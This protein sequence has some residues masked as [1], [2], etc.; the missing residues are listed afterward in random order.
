MD[1]TLT[2]H[3]GRFARRAYFRGWQEYAGL[4][5]NARHPRDLARHPQW[6][7]Q[8]GAATMTL[9]IPWWPYDAPVWVAANLPPEARVFEYGGGGS[10]LWLE[11]LGAAVTAVEHD[12]QWHAQLAAAVS[13]RTRLLFR[14]PHPAGTVT[15]AVAPSYFDTYA[16]AIDAEPDGNLD[17]VIVDGRARVECA[18][19]AMSKVRPGGLLIL[20]D[21]DRARYEPAVQMLGGWERR[22]FAGLKP[23]QR[24]PAQTSAWRRPT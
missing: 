14:P 11:D 12:A 10:T 4:A 18:R 20:D 5:Y 13:P 24:I 2:R 3:F 19:R 8:R 17:L 21:T 7:R 22:V 6:L 16:A 23:G 9:R 1:V 15:S